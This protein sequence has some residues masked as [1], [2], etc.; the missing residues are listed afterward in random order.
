MWR[1]MGGMK[2][3]SNR[4]YASKYVYMY[5]H[6]CVYVCVFVDTEW[7]ALLTSVIAHLGAHTVGCR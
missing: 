1:G 6:G 5:L 3:C 4:V 2:E 7:K